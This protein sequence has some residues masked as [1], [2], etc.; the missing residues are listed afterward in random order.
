ML[1]SPRTEILKIRSWNFDTFLSKAGEKH[2]ELDNIMQVNKSQNCF[3]TCQ[4]RLPKCLI[5][6]CY[7]A[8]IRAVEKCVLRYRTFSVLQPRRHY[9]TILRIRKRLLWY[10]RDRLEWIHR[11]YQDGLLE[12]DH[13]KE[14]NNTS[15]SSSSWPCC[16]LQDNSSRT[17]GKCSVME[18]S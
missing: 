7:K 12:H 18:K 5:R 16:S 11:R 13:R 2:D 17:R 9:P 15:A 8:R 4:K 6:F 1:L 14:S 10:H 3:F